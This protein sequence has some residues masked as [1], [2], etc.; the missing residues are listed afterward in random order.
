MACIIREMLPLLDGCIAYADRAPIHA[1]HT[2]RTGAIEILVKSLGLH[3]D[4]P[5]TSRLFYIYKVAIA[6][7]TERLKPDPWHFRT[8]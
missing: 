3:S 2:W 1:V 4:L 6:T 5:T 7:F 8:R